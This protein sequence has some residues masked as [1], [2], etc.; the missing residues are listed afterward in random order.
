MK[1][2][3]LGM[4]LY[5]DIDD[6]NSL[7]PIISLLF[8]TYKSKKENNKID[9]HDDKIPNLLINLYYKLRRDD[10]E[11]DIMKSKFIEHYIKNE[12]E[13]ELI[14]PKE[15]IDGLKEVYSFIHTT[16]II[17]YYEDNK[18][19]NY[20]VKKYTPFMLKK[21]HE[22]L[23]SLA[24]Y[25]EYAGTFRNNDVYLPGTGTDLL[26]WSYIK[27]AVDDIDSEVM[28]IIA[29]SFDISSSE[30]VEDI[31]DYLDECIKIKCKLIKIHPFRDGNGRTIRAF[32]N[33][34]LERVG[35]PPVYICASERTEY[36]QAMN[37]ANNE[38][39]YSLI[40]TFYRFKICDSII[41]LGI[42]PKMNKDEKVK[43]R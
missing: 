8:E 10:V 9:L 35:L 31:L 11:F 4:A 36:D 2:N 26:D 13:L 34:L 29:K 28:N 16:N 22:K 14:H 21:I 27:S 3:D 43:I 23:Y 32:I 33:I 1:D 18:K 7:Y 5:Q 19:S 41:E 12:S 25:S 40:N 24:P 30:K 39:D 42:N 15:E 6:A 37:L 20:F 38:G 17:K